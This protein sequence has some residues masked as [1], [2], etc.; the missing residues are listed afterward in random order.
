MSVPSRYRCASSPFVRSKGLAKGLVSLQ[1]LRSLHICGELDD[2]LHSIGKYE[3]VI[4]PPLE[5]PTFVE[6]ELGKE[7]G[8]VIDDGVPLEVKCIADVL[9]VDPNDRTSDFGILYL[10]TARVQAVT[11]AE[12]DIL[13]SCAGTI[14]Y[15]ENNSAQKSVMLYADQVVGR[16]S[17]DLK[18]SPLHCHRKFRLRHWKP[19]LV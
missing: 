10:Y 14:Y 3:A 17:K 16:S 5:L 13:A 11:A 6:T 15:L 4:H 8:E 2:W 19:L 12:D 18:H 1:C 7:E 9:A